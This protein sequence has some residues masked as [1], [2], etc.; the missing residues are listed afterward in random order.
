MNERWLSV[1]EVAAYLGIKRFTVY[2]WVKRSSLPV[3]KIGRLLKFRKSEIDDWPYSVI[4]AKSIRNKEIRC[5]PH[6]FVRF[7][8]K[9]R[10]KTRE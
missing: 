2:K 5:E 10:R 3:R 7:M 8:G 6:R 4:R 9:R 1:D